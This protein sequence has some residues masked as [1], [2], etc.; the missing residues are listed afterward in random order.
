MFFM[1]MIFIKYYFTQF[2]IVFQLLF[3]QFDY[4]RNF[5]VFNVINIVVYKIQD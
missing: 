5:D 2:Y 3:F 4:F 1:I